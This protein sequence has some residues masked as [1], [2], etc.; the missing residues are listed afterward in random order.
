MKTDVKFPDKL[1]S[2]IEKSFQKCINQTEREFMEE[3]LKKICD[4]A[5]TKGTMF[6]RDWDA[7]RLPSLPRENK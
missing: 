5:K 2:Y 6:L 3:V 7:L 1:G 4:T